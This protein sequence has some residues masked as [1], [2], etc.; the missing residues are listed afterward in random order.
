M[1]TFCKCWLQLLYL[2]DAEDKHIWY[3]C[4][5]PSPQQ[6]CL[7]LHSRKSSQNLSATIRTECIL[8]F[9]QA[10]QNVLCVTLTEILSSTFVG[11]CVTYTFN[12]FPHIFPHFVLLI[13]ESNNL[14]FNP[15]NAEL[16]PICHLL[17]LLGAHHILHIGRIRVKNRASSIQDGCTATLQMLHF[18]YFFSTNIS[19]EYF[20]HAAHSLFFSSKCRLF[21]N[22]TFFGSCIIH[23]LHTGCAKI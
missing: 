13:L 8:Y 23:I 1:V 19:T 7:W 11:H 22:A 14:N 18:I 4:S 9:V 16:N 20:K 10:V 12:G 3:I 21:Y 6:N 2:E 5:S 17:A 15:L